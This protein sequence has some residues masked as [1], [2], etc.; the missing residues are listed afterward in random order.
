MG[1]IKSIGASDIG[2]ELFN[3]LETAHNR[4]QYYRALI[5]ELIKTDSVV[6]DK[7]EDT[8]VQAFKNSNDI[9]QAVSDKI[10]ELGY[11]EAKTWNADFLNR[12]VDAIF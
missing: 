6:P 5:I 7:L 12:R 9:K 11:V 2:D 4:D 8:S 10:D 1:E 3:A